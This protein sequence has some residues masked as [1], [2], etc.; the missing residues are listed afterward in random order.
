MDTLT[1][2]FSGMLLARATAKVKTNTPQLPLHVR[3]WCGFLAAAF[4]DADFV[5]RYFGSLSY[6]EYHRGVTHSLLMLP[7]WAVLLA[8]IF[9]LIWRRRY[10]WQ[11][12]VGVSAMS[13]LIH[14][15]GDVITAYGTMVFAPLTGWRLAMPTTFIIDLYFSGVI[16]FALILAWIIKSKGQAIAVSGLVVLCVYISAQGYWH[17][18]ANLVAQQKVK[19]MGLTQATISVLPQPLSPRHW[20]LMLEANQQYHIAYLNLGNTQT[21]KIHSEESFWR[22]LK[23]LYQ[24][25]ADLQWETVHQYGEGKE[26]RQLAQAAWSIPVLNV[27]HRF[28]RYPSLFDMETRAEGICAWF[29]DQRF[30]LRGLRAPFRFGACRKAEG[31]WKAYRYRDEGLIPVLN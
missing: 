8:F 17:H 27:L 13:L 25:A 28:M 16:L 9:T 29:V 6:F 11:L 30:V 23:S 7:L 26:T 3:M 14:I 31:N 1:H 21:D 19:E 24:P 15:L 4:P 5:T 22:K 20:K 12:F 10:R 2:A 18:Q